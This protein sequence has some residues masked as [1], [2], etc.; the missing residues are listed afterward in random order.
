MNHRAEGLP[1]SDDMP[2]PRVLATSVLG[3]AIGVVMLNSRLARARQRRQRN[4]RNFVFPRSA[5]EGVART[6][7]VVRE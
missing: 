4:T 1:L 6:E 7:P 3:T 2:M 5:V